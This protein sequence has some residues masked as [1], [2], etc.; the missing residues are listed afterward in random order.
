MTLRVAKGSVWTF[1]GLVLPLAVSLVTTPFVIRM[2]GPEAYGVVILVSLLVANLGFAD[3]GMSIASTKFAS[4]EYAKGRPES[5]ARI[6]RTAALISIMTSLP[7]AIAVFLLAEKFTDLF[8]IPPHLRHDATVTF[9]L[10]AAI[11]VISLLNQVFNT[12]QLARLR[13]DVNTLISA[14]ARIGALIATPLVLFA[15]GGVVGAISVLFVT[16]L[17]TLVGHLYASSCLLPSLRG[18]SIQLSAV[19]SLLKFGAPLV[20]AT[21]A[22][23]FVANL[24]KLILPGIVSVESLAFYSVAFTLASTMT[25]FSSSM[26]QSLIPAFSQLQGPETRQQLEGLYLRGLRINVICLMPGLVFLAIAARPFFTLWAGEQFGAESTPI[27]HILLAGLILNVPA[28][29]PASLLMASG[30]TDLLAKLYVG[31]L[32]PYV[33]L[34]VFLTWQYGARG[35]AAAWTLRIAIDAVLIFAIAGRANRLHVTPSVFYPIFK[36]ALILLV[37]LAVAVYYGEVNTAVVVS[38]AACGCLY[39]WMIHRTALETDEIAWLTQKVHAV[40]PGQ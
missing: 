1:I 5:E 9:R 37:P 39:A 38:Y 28:Y 18:F 25:M 16:T 20:I 17:L 22:A 27:F 34:V 31:E 13:M 7:F 10:A 11:L 29:L 30:R 15:G 40:F 6:V 4:E 14:G 21:I 8:N 12:P 35:A 19:G 26:A 36:S 23:L 33:F 2:L 24:E 3:L 32:V